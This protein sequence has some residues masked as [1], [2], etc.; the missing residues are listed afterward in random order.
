MLQ[1]RP[2]ELEVVTMADG[3]FLV[4][5]DKKEPQR[6]YAVEFDYDKWS[7]TINNEEKKEMPKGVQKITIE[8]EES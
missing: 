7:Y 4:K 8:I 6:C 2:G 5:F 1:G 3:G